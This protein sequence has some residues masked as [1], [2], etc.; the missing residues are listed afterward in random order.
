VGN[1]TRF[2][3]DRHHG[4]LDIVDPGG[5]RVVRNEYDDAGRLVATVDAEG[6][7]VEITHQLGTRQEVVKDRLGNVTVLEYDAV[8]N[9]VRKTDALG[10]ITTYTFD[11]SG[12]QLSETDP[13]GRVATRTWNAPSISP[14]SA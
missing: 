13:L 7:R 6:R 4:L 10:G 2:T 11:A 8:G 3:Y 9:I 14:S 5:A 1:V 12:N